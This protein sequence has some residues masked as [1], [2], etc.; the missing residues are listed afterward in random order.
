[1]KNAQIDVKTF[2]LRARS[3]QRTKDLLL[4]YSEF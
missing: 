2:N 3:V 1:M 4:K